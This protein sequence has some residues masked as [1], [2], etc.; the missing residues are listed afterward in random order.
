MDIITLTRF[1]RFVTC[2]VCRAK[3]SSTQFVWTHCRGRFTCRCGQTEWTMPPANARPSLPRRLAWGLAKLPFRLAWGVA[4]SLPGVTGLFPVRP[5]RIVACAQVAIASAI[6][7]SYP[8]ARAIVADLA[9]PLWQVP[10]E[11]A[12]QAWEWAASVSVPRGWSVAAAATTAAATT[13][14]AIAAQNRIVRRFNN[15]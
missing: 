7:A 8:P 4:K 1:H 2:P 5:E 13:A 3:Y 14:A 15:A 11:W 6:V 9:A 12:S 10:L